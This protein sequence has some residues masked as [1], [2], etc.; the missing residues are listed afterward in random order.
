MTSPFK[1]H[2]SSGS[3]NYAAHSPTYPAR[4]VDEL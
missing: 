3:A 4:L 1:D 2:F